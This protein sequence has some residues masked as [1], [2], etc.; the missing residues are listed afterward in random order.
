MGDLGHEER[1]GIEEVLGRDTAYLAECS[2]RKHAQRD[3]VKQAE[4]GEVE[5]GCRGDVLTGERIASAYGGKRVLMSG[6]SCAVAT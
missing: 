4:P 6:V 3:A 5:A 2:I 1:H